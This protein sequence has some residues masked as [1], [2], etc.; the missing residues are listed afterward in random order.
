MK[1]TGCTGVILAGGLNM[2][3]GGRNK[4]LTEIEG[5]TLLDRTLSAFSGL[6][7]ETMVVANT[8]LAFLSC[9]CL[10][11]TDIVSLRTPLAGIH[12]ALN[13]AK[14]P[15]I[16]VTAC[17][18]PFLSTALIETILQKVDT[19]SDVIVPDTEKGLQPLCAVYAKTCLPLI[20][21]QLKKASAS[22]PKDKDKPPKRIL[23]QGLKILNFYDHVR[24]KKIPEDSLCRV[25]PDLLSFFNINTPE[26]F[27]HAA[28]ILSKNRIS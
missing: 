28:Q 6:F 23:S 13:Y 5:K 22:A 9:S 19:K 21:K 20:E 10:L 7:P 26:D 24:V 16:F 25:D 11:V 1:Y 8:P 3:F 15:Y 27:A 14:T 4:A 18:T 2:R 17:D 12:A